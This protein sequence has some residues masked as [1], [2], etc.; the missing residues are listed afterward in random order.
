MANVVCA[1]CLE[2]VSDT[3]TVCRNCGAPQ[4]PQRTSFWRRTS[5]WV[6]AA[7]AGFFALV[8]FFAW[9]APPAPVSPSPSTEQPA[10]PPKQRSEK[11]VRNVGSEARLIV[12]SGTVLVAADEAAYKRFLT[13]AVA[14]DTLGI[15]DMVMQ[16]QAFLVPNGTKVKV[17]DSG[18][19]RREVRILEGEHF[20]RSGWVAYEF[21]RE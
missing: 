4:V 19:A 9:V 17:I 18:F 6:W 14:D 2:L 7:I 8:A 3:T 10:P 11:E 16:G 12:D 5:G 1:K 21:L 15:A 13:L 20:G